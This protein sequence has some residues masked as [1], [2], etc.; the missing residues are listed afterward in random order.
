M[1][2]AKKIILICLLLLSSGCSNKTPP[3]EQLALQIPLPPILIGFDSVV[4]AKA[5]QQQP[6]DLTKS[7]Y[8]SSIS[9]AMFFKRLLNDSGEN[10]D[11]EKDIEIT[12][13]NSLCVMGKFLLS[14]KY[15]DALNLK[16]DVY[17]EFY[18]WLSKKQQKWESLLSR[19]DKRIFDVPCSTLK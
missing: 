1:L 15:K 11:F 10:D 3:K 16:G 14:D 12:Q 8:D 19:Q 9:K 13:I 4:Y 2:A 6:S 7:I 17:T 5:L 18:G